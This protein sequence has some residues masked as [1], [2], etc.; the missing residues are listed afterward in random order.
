M[1]MD[2]ASLSNLYALTNAGMCPNNAARTNMGT[3]ANNSTGS[4]LDIFAQCNIFTDYGA[5]V[6]K[7][8]RWRRGVKS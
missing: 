7:P 8:R 3:I 6:A 4:Y 1:V 2:A 5:G